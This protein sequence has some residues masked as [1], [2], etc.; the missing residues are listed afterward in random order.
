MNTQEQFSLARCLSRYALARSAIRGDWDTTGRKAASHPEGNGQAGS[1]GLWRER[2]KG[3]E[4]SRGAS[5][6]TFIFFLHN[7]ACHKE[8]GF[9]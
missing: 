9:L 6:E 1:Q 4:G 7:F 5:C 8:Q 3:A 2:W